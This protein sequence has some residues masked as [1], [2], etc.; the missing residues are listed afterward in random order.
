MTRTLKVERLT[1]RVAGPPRIA[2][3]ER[4]GGMVID[5]IAIEVAEAKNLGC[6]LVKLAHEVE[7]EGRRKP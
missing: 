6:D 4:E 7:R 5:T 3:V 2:L 1:L